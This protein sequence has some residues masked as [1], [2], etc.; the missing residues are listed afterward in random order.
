MMWDKNGIDWIVYHTGLDSTNPSHKY[1]EL[2]DNDTV[3]DTTVMWND[4][5]PTSSVFSVGTKIKQCK[6]CLP[7]CYSAGVLMG[8]YLETALVKT[9][10]VVRVLG[11]SLNGKHWF[12]I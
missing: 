7:F 6:H 4:T 2:N 3:K 12:P 8:S 11:L 10:I 5:E 1:L 9:L